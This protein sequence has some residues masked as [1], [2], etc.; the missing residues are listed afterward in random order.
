[1][2]RQRCLAPDGVDSYLPSMFRGLPFFL[3]L[4]LAACGPAGD[5]SPT[6][7]WGGAPPADA[8]FA[9]DQT[10]DDDP[11]TGVDIRDSEAVVPDVVEDAGA[12]DSAGP[13]ADDPEEP[14]DSPDSA[15]GIVA[16]E[17]VLAR[18]CEGDVD[19]YML[20]VPEGHSASVRIL[21]THA[22][23]DL[24]LRV[25]RGQV[26][27]ASSQSERDL[28]DFSAPVVD[29]IRTYLVEVYGYNGALGPY[30]IVGA[31]FGVPHFQGLVEGSVAYEDRLFG[32]NGF[33]GEVAHS[34]A[35]GLTVE[36]VREA[37]GA[38]IA[39][40][41]TAI[42]GGFSLPYPGHAGRSY[43]A[44]VLAQVA[45]EGLR[46][47][48]RD[49]SS[50]HL[51]YALGSESWQ[52]DAAPAVV[53]VAP[54]DHA[55]G[56]A[57][58]VADQLGLGLRF[59]RQHTDEMAPVLRVRWERG[60]PFDCGSC[61]GGDRIYLGG[62]PDDPDQYDDD[63]ILHEFAHWV[64][65]RFSRDDSPGGTHRDRLVSP[66]LAYGEGMAYFFSAMVRDD[67]TV[68][69][70]F[71]EGARHIDLEAVTQNMQALAELSGTSDGTL[72]GD[73]REEIPAAILWDAYDMASDDE[74][75]D[76]VSIGAEGHMEVLISFRDGDSFPDV[77]PVGVDL[78]DWLNVASCLYPEV[79]GDL[80]LIA[81][82]R[83]YPFDPDQHVDCAG[84]S[85]GDIGL[86]LR[87]FGAELELVAPEGLRVDDMR[88]F[89]DGVA[90]KGA[91]PGL[92]CL[93]RRGTAQEVA[94]S[95]KV[96]GV[97]YGT[98]WMTQKRSD[99][100]RGGRAAYGV[101]LYGQLL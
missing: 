57:L 1:M 45:V 94:V 8:A 55:I 79:A 89:V 40:G 90:V 62:A 101:R 95:V 29:E 35:R 14:N 91:C 27:V 38:I 67:P 100:L 32:P 4:S 37:D 22:D 56:G 60:A 97:R 69:D 26:N 76:Q 39:T 72:S 21:F 43:H 82:D 33:T 19:W 50:A 17:S 61:Y 88:V 85:G 71:I 87:E 9:D 70:N 59:L 16:G 23:G 86:Q 92:P 80:V 13:C 44:R 41:A 24:D 2:V 73:M 5:L 3:T 99:Q 63:I 66:R 18:I 20:T 93:I 46:A 81:A 65:H 34:A 64:V 10:A 7:P 96:R 68:T 74:A 49:R 12:P 6:G 47:E 75:F 54:A 98:S 36:V 52:G 83:E 30:S 11:D 15:V 42:E 28:E 48:V 53:L 31:D 84:K 25:W 77:G 78:S 51:L 58:N